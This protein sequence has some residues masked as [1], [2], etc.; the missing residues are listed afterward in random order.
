HAFLWQKGR[1][2]DLGTL[3]VT[4][5]SPGSV[6]FAI[7]GKGQVVGESNV[8]RNEWHACSWVDGNIVDL[9]TLPFDRHSCATAINNKGVI[10]GF[11]GLPG[12]TAKRHAFI[13]NNDKMR[14]LNTFIDSKA[15]WTLERADSINENG[16]IVGTGLHN[17]ERRAYL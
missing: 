3:P 15:G 11:V 13:C 9:G 17:G 10:V 5:T 16:Q 7:N 2:Q 1:M 4:N 8:A 14:D 6:A 12:E